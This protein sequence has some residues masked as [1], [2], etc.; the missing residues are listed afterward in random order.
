M[1]IDLKQKGPGDFRPTFACWYSQVYNYLHFCP[2]SSTALG[3]LWVRVKTRN[4]NNLYISVL[5]C[6]ENSV[7][8]FVLFELSLLQI[9]P[10]LYATPLCAIPMSAQGLNLDPST[11]HHDMVF[12]IPQR[13]YSTFERGI[14]VITLLLHYV[15]SKNQPIKTCHL[16][17]VSPILTRFVPMF[18]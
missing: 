4:K 12:D 8:Y 15:K 3:P 10:W 14:T 9:H 1:L 7:W 5:A 16:Q 17:A 13:S 2:K 11:H 18:G 6:S